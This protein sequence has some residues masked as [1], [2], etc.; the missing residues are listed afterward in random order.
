MEPEAVLRVK[1]FETA[2]CV[3]YMI[4]S[5]NSGSA[6]FSVIADPVSRNAVVKFSIVPLLILPE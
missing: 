1:K 3:E 2:G 5:L 6:S 4:G